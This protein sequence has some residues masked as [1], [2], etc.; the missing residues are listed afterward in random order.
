MPYSDRIA[1][2]LPLLG[3]ASAFSSTA[4]LLPTRRSA[5]M[6]AERTAAD[7]CRTSPHAVIVTVWPTAHAQASAARAWVEQCGGK[8]LHDAEVAIGKQGAI[9]TCLALYSGEEWL[10]TNCWYGESPLPTGP[11]DG[12]HAGAR[13]K[14]CAR[15]PWFRDANLTPS[16]RRRAETCPLQ[17]PFL[18]QAALTWTRDAPLTVL[19]VDASETGGALWSSKYRVR[20]Q[21]RREVGGLG[22][23]CVH[24]TDNQ[25][26]ALDGRGASGA[27]YAC[28]SSYAYHCAR[29]LL[30]ESSVRFLAE[31]DADAAAFEERFAAYESW[32][33]REDAPVGGAPSFVV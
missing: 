22:N 25:A 1:L 28:D 29:V 26:A 21:L 4:R 5:V 33:A 3:C 12:P 32:L 30:D 31:A 10:E 6:T 17:T 16:P 19:V 14:V 7:F 15:C 27:G 24:L 18:T 8:I 11:P 9:A 2:L 23:C 13:W 20:E